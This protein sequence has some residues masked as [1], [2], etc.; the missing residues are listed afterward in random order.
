MHGFGAI[1]PLFCNAFSHTFCKLQIVNLSLRNFF[2]HM[3][4][5]I[6]GYKL[7]KFRNFRL[8]KFNYSAI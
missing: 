7:V 1:H 8:L 2:Y 6:G 5:V 4:T 3:I